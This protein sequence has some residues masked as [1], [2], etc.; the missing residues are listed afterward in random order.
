[1]ANKVY[2]IVCYAKDLILTGSRCAAE[3]LNFFRNQREGWFT[4]TI[5]EL[6]ETFLGQWGRHAIRKALELLHEL[7]LIDRRHHRLNARAWQYQY[8]GSERQSQSSWDDEPTTVVHEPT[9]VVHEPT[10]T[11]YIDPILDPVN[12]DPPQQQ[13]A[14]GEEKLLE[15]EPDWDAVAQQSQE[16]EQ[17][18][19]TELPAQE[20]QSTP[21][22]SVEEISQDSSLEESIPHEENSPAVA[23]VAVNKINETS[24][25]TENLEPTKEQIDQVCRE[26]RELRINLEVGLLRKN[27]A[28]VAGAIAFIREEMKNGVQPKK[29]WTAYFRWALVMGVKPEKIQAP[30]DF[31]EWYTWAY[32]QGFV[33]R[34]ELREDGV[35]GVCLRAE[36]AA[37]LGV[38]QWV[39]FEK[40]V[41]LLG[42]AK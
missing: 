28:N 3:L 29:S 40:A 42:G 16:W 5:D 15:Q 20:N 39:R 14:V 7:R 2:K 24:E 12:L 30:T 34:S 36:V 26:L 4:I 33:E 10:T 27:W 11:I 25:T 31:G 41:E 23:P 6:V 38:Q 19:N 8:L 9:T 17:A 13:V 18:Q 32:R 37:H 21:T 35:M 22:L 1:M